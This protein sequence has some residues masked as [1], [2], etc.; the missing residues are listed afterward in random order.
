L[1]T[2]LFSA[3]ATSALTVMPIRA[4]GHSYEGIRITAR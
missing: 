2:S 3:C 4:I 1:S